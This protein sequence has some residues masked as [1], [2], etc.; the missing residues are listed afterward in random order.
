MMSYKKL[1]ATLLSFFPFM[2]TVYATDR[3]FDL[4]VYGGS[5]SG[6]IAAYA[7]AKEGLKVALLVEGRHVGG[8]TTSGLGSVDYGFYE[9]IGGYTNKFFLDVA[10]QYGSKKPAFLLEP[11]VAEKT[12]LK[13]LEDAGVS[14]FYNARLKEKTGVIK[15]GRNIAQLLTENGDVFRAKMFIDAS[16]EADLMAWAKVSY[17]Y[18]RESRAQYG[19]SEAGVGARPIVPVKLQEKKLE[20][21]KKIT[22]EFP[23]DYLYGEPG[24]RF[25]A[26]NKT[27]AYTFRLTL[28]TKEGN[29]VPFSKPDGYNPARYK[30]LLDKILQ[31]K[32]T[33]FDDVCT[34]YKL[35]N[36]KTDVNHLDLVNAGHEYPEGTYAEREKIIQYHK[37]YEMGY[38]YFVANDPAVPEALRTDAQRWGLAKDEFA[39]NGH[40]PYLLYTR[41]TRRMVGAYVMRQQDAW[42]EP[43][44]DDVIGMG[45]Y[46]ID[47]HEVQQLITPGGYLVLEGGHRYLP[48]R[49]YQ[50]AYRSITPKPQDCENLLVTTCLSSS[51][52][53]YGSL[54]MEPVYMILGHSAG[55]AA[56]M[57]IKGKSSVQQV[58]V[59]QLQ[60]KLKAQGQIFEFHAPVGAYLEKKDY[61]GAIV[62]DFE[63]TMTGKWGRGWKTMPFLIGGYRTANKSTQETHTMTFS[64]D[65]PQ[66]GVYEVYIIYAPDKNR[67]TNALVTVHSANGAKELRVDQTQKP[68]DG[69]YWYPLGR[70]TFNKGSRGKVVFSNKGAD[71]VVVADAV[72][73]V[74]R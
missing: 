5:S 18:G 53:I 20:E 35:P 16:Y 74:R 51:H 55:V 67:A 68:V 7:G 59:S 31:N 49:P 40:W 19:E 70:Y 56:A 38:L 45:S 13:M 36:G 41:E 66:K 37:D 60:N 72:R 42:E 3:E 23:L 50:I 44:K 46:G 32:Y 39:D 30:F 2:Q 33:R 29:K 12:F 73:F 63:T 24:K 21:I 9:T 43:T 25:S 28:T 34:I 4:V 11:S 57:A 58:P 26:D 52:V 6:V 14:L 71:G 62:D 10:A 47:F 17:T 22:R 69:S 64:P 61:D 54:R 8:L 65:L 15:Q 1:L 27:Q 48:F